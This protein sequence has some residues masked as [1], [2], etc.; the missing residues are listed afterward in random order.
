MALK[1]IIYKAAL[2]FSD[3]DENVYS[4]HQLTLARHPSET[5]ERMMLRLVAFALH[6]PTNGDNGYLEFAKDMWD[7]D[8]PCIWQPDLTG[9]LVQWIDMGQPEEKR[10]MR[11]AGRSKR[12]AVYTYGGGSAPWWNGV[13]D[14]INRAQNVEVWQVSQEQVEALA[15]LANRSMQIQITVQDGIVYVECAGTTVELER[16][17]LK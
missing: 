5:D 1:A 12:V 7:P 6:A 9:A 8:E 4:D 10:I 15:A 2:Q 17:R 16:V 3:L 13:S 14:K 11:A